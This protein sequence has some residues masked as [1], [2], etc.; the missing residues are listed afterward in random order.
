MTES[1]GRPRGRPKGSKNKKTVERELEQQAA[2]DLINMRV[3]KRAAGATLGKEILEY[4]MKYFT[5]AAKAVQPFIPPGT[6]ENP[7][8]VAVKNPG[9]QHGLFMQ[10]ARLSKE[11]AA[12]LTPFQ[13]PRFGAVM[14][15]MTDEAEEV[16]GRIERVI[17]DTA[18]GE[19]IDLTAVK[20]DSSRRELE[21]PPSPT[22]PAP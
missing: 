14:V 3:E 20:T 21:S 22:P 15:G 19:T 12:D 5:L 6:K 4:W 16:I 9:Y 1:N 7:G 17:I 10:F 8:E 2:D 18:T 13:S 11:C